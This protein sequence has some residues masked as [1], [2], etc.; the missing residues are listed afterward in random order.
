MILSIRPF[1]FS[2]G[3]LA[4]VLAAERKRERDEVLRLV[5]LAEMPAPQSTGRAVSALGL[6]DPQRCKGDS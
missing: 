3:T 4:D 5:Q 6:A 1:R 2:W